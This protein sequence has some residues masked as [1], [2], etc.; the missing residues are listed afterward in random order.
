MAIVQ[1]LIVDKSKSNQFRIIVRDETGSFNSSN[2]TGY[3]GLNG[4]P[5]SNISRYIFDIYNVNT[6]QSYRQ[7]QSDNL[8]IITDYHNP[9]LNRIANKEDVELNSDNFDL[10]SFNDGVYKIIMNTEFNTNLFGE[11]FEGQEVINNVQSSKSI[12]D[13]YDGIIVNNEIY[14]ITNEVEGVLILDRPIVSD[15]TSFKPILRSSKTFI[16][17]DKL[18]DC[19]NKKIATTISNCLCDDTQEIK[20]I[21]ELQL[22][23]WGITR[24]IDK[25]DYTQA[26]IY[27]DLLMKICSS[28]NCNC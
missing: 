17:Y 19:I 4:N 15:F 18:N 27:I 26:K 6:N 20:S 3:G 10:E 8:D 21:A 13:N 9:A 1:K 2:T 24:S 22:L 14:I 11:G 23:D 7:I 5:I 25:E 28:L 12:Y 16:L